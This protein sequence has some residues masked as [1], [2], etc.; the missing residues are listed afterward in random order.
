M[1]V[2]CFTILKCNTYLGVTDLDDKNYMIY[3]I[4]KPV[5]YVLKNTSDIIIILSL[6]AYL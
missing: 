1:Y 3:L 4:K 2:T 5:L 6:I